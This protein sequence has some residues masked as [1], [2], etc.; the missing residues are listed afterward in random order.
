[1]Y[2]LIGLFDKDTESL[3]GNIRN[4]LHD[5][6]NAVPCGR[7]HLSLA[8]YR[9]LDLETYITMMDHYLSS[10]PCLPLNFQSI[11][12]FMEY[13]A[14]FLTPV[15][16]KEL[17]QFHIDYYEHFKRF[18][19]AANEHYLPD[20]WVPHCTMISQM[21]K[22]Q[23]VEGLSACLHLFKPFSAKIV[24]VALVQD[25]GPLVHSASLKKT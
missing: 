10:L 18:R 14:C 7:P 21:P 24:E 15:M 12:V 9:E 8:G 25:G 6:F 11:G 3:I 13:P 22:D 5:K 16:T 20:S 4:D 23:M 17:M 19:F 2:W 1:M